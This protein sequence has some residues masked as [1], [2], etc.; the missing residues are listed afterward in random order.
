MGN[1]FLNQDTLRLEKGYGGNYSQIFFKGQTNDDGRIIHWEDNNSSQLWLMPSDDNGVASDEVILGTI[2]KKNGTTDLNGATWNRAFSFVMDGTMKINSKSSAT[3]LN[4]L[5]HESNCLTSDTAPNR[6]ENYC[7]V[8]TFGV[9]DGYT[10]QLAS[11]YGVAGRYYIR[12]QQDTSKSWKVWESII[13]S[14]QRNIYKLRAAGNY[15]H[16][17]T[18]NG[19]KGINWW[20]SDIKFKN[21]IQIIDS[22]NKEN[23]SLDSEIPGLDLV[24]KIKHYSFDYDETHNNTHI[25]CGY[26]AQQLEEIDERLIIKIEQPKDSIYYSEEDK[27]TRQ[28][29]AN[30]IIPYL[31]KAIQELY[32]KNIEL[33]NRLKDIENSNIDLK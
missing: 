6:P 10:M 18:N 32:A 15:M 4:G 24:N 22:S 13:T 2:A 16:I 23:R 7:Y 30:V 5:Y 26:I 17:E 14:D 1:A 25:D 3:D 28:P 21:N 29:N 31:S 33:E 27:Y 20:E 12:S 8:R 11:Y 19:A 9:N